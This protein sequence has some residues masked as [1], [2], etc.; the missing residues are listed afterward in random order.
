MSPYH[1][2]FSLI[3]LL[4]TVAIIGILSAI[5]VPQY[6]EYTQRAR[7]SEGFSALATVQPAA[8][9]YWANKRTFEGFDR[10]PAATA[11]FTFAL[12]ESSVS[13]YVVKATG[14][15]KASGFSYTIN[16][17]G[18]RA[19]T[20]APSAYGTSTSCWVDRKGGACTN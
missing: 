4:V 17:S 11:N 2:G 13:A 5:A 19:T 18:T 9:H 16:Q 3:E 15:A 20:A 7:L 6:Q 12:T 10:L 14:R 8:E 1:R